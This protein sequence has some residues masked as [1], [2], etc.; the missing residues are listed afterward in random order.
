MASE[1]KTALITGGFGYIGSHVT[2]AL[3]KAGWRTIVVD[4]KSIPQSH[5]Y[6]DMFYPCDIGAPELSFLF[7]KV[8]IDVV[9][10]LA[11]LIEVGTSEKC[12]SEYYQVNVGGTIN[13][14]N[15]MAIH[16]VKNIVFSS[17]AGVYGSGDV[18]F[19]ETDSTIPTSV[20]GR[21][22]LMCEQIITD[23]QK[24][25][26]NSICLRYFNVGGADPD[27]QM[28][29]NHEP[30]THLIPRIFQNLNN[31][32]LYGDDYDTPDGTCIRDFIH[33]SDVAD[34]HVA[35]AEYLLKHQKSDI[36][37]IG[38]GTGYSNKQIVDTIEKVTGQNVNITYGPRRAGDPAILVANISKAQ[39]LLP[40]NPKF[41]LE[42]IIST[43]YDWH[44]K[45]GDN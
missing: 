38:S 5:E 23:M 24:E 11:G 13:L 39:E 36:F 41:S 17:S 25:N 26:I 45:H 10:H 20:Y 4:S 33:V 18:K 1:M 27:G 9:F 16:H 30:E 34:A 12:P 35:S 3:K 2:K 37:N 44:L 40:F 14:L 15:E 32:T 29:E 42:Y 8:K 22:K 28:G 6:T 7:G 19:I 31:F 43:A 21:N